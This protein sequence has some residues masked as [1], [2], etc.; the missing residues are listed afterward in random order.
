MLAVYRY[1]DALISGYWSLI[2]RRPVRAPL[3]ASAAAAPFPALPLP[4]GMASGT[5]AGMWRPPDPRPLGPQAPSL[6]PRAPG[7]FTRRPY[8]V[9]P[10]RRRNRHR[11]HPCRRLAVSGLARARCRL[12]T[13]QLPEKA[14]AVTRHWGRLRRDAQAP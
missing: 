10:A 1:L 8:V 11:P 4:L 6:A 14:C 13:P 7:R 5:H 3:L 2:S 9:D 12:P